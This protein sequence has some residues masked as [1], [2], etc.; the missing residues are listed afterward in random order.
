MRFSLLAVLTALSNPAFGQETQPPTTSAPKPGAAVIKTIPSF[1]KT[2]AVQPLDEGYTAK[3]REYTTE[4]YFL[5]ELVD[6][7]P[8]SNKVP[9]PEKV[10]G[11][12]S[13]AIGKLTYTADVNRYFRELEKSSKRVKVFSMGKSEEGR[14]MIVAAISD[15]AN[16]RKLGRL[17][18]ITGRLADPRKTSDGDAEKLIREGKVLYHATG[19]MHSPETGSP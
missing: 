12:V 13:G 18:E 16:L 14:E 10:L 15:E 11:Y 2:A 7:L 1:S 6:H 19:A 3:I 4:P 9:T 5:T 8:A 17:K